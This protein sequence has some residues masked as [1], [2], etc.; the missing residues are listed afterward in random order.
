MRNKKKYSSN[1]QQISLHRTLNLHKT[2][3]VKYYFTFSNLQTS[4]GHHSA[5][6]R[7]LYPAF[8]TAPAKSTED[9]QQNNTLQSNV[10]VPVIQANNIKHEE[11][12]PET[13]TATENTMSDEKK[14]TKQSSENKIATLDLYDST[15]I[16]EG[17]GTYENYFGTKWQEQEQHNIDK[18]LKIVE[19]RT[20]D[21]EPKTVAHRTVAAN[22]ALA[23]DRKLDASSS[24]MTLA[25]TPK[26]QKQMQSSLYNKN[27]FDDKNITDSAVLTAIDS[28]AG[29]VVYMTNTF[30]CIG[31]TV[32]WPG[33]CAKNDCVDETEAENTIDSEF[34][35]KEIDAKTFPQLAVIYLDRGEGAIPESR[36]AMPVLCCVTAATLLKTYD[37][38][39]AEVEGAQIQ[40][41]AK[42]DQ[43]I[44][45]IT[46]YRDA[47]KKW[48][49]SGNNPKSK[50]TL[51]NYCL[52][53]DEKMRSCKILDF[54]EATHTKGS[55]EDK[56]ARRADNL[57]E[58]CRRTNAITLQ[59]SLNLTWAQKEKSPLPTT[60]LF[61]Y[62]FKVP[63]APHQ[64]I[65]SWN[66]GKE[67]PADK[68]IFANYGTEVTQQVAATPKKTKSIKKEQKDDDD[69]DGDGDND[70]DEE[71]DAK[72]KK[73][74]AKK[75]PTAEEI[76]TATPK[77]TSKAVKAAATKKKQSN[78]DD[79]DVDDKQQ[80]DDDNENDEVKQK[81]TKKNV[82]PSIA[83][84]NGVATQVA[85]IPD[86]DTTKPKK[87]GGKKATNKRQRDED[88]EDDADDVV[89]PEPVKKSSSKIAANKM[90]VDDATPKATSST[91]KKEKPVEVQHKKAKTTK[92]EAASSGIAPNVNENGL[93]LWNEKHHAIL[94]ELATLE[95]F[96]ATGGDAVTDD[97]GYGLW[98]NK[99]KEDTLELTTDGIDNVLAN[100]VTTTRTL[101]YP[102]LFTDLAQQQEKLR[103]H[104]AKVEAE[105]A[106]AKLKAEQEAAEAEAKKKAHAEEI[107]KKKSAEAA[108]AK[109]QAEEEELAVAKQKE[110]AAKAQKPM[111]LAEKM[112]NAKKMAAIVNSATLPKPS[113]DED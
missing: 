66:G 2:V 99:M 85:V 61:V 90:A 86:E 84:A 12:Q 46:K 97:I 70:A 101:G 43:Y 5:A 87:G 73:G 56:A 41:A 95:E 94:Q 100:T 4:A 71:E 69:D 13:T 15:A 25:L 96:L 88:E 102:R 68:E 39:L 103:K 32:T 34:Y 72:P 35:S 106:A 91:P 75:H 9:N 17:C 23:S 52:V 107:T 50:F 45:L 37:D 11:K 104:L 29:K 33:M 110:E 98:A 65:I 80:G 81:S 31:G 44:L 113:I 28:R 111:T 76:A 16:L 112:A 109:K 3:K 14:P 92:D 21:A 55:D 27:P 108:A 62:S 40:N 30:M 38:R 79:D 6:L 63:L 78:D 51:F 105:A 20:I 67:N 26:K 1:C 54:I 74:G 93:V 53:S 22:M 24:S 36:H 48:I 7:K 59:L 10:Q 49:Q 58:I 42:K 19:I 18:E 82:A 8:D 89:E 60:A 47:L 83:V 77:A 64:K 57:K